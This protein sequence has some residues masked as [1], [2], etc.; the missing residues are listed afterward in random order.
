MPEA[1]SKFSASAAERWMGCPG[2]MVLEVG[3]ADST[4]EYAAE[5]TVAHD[6]AAQ[7]LRENSPVDGRRA[8]HFLG[9][10]MSADGFD[11]V[12]DE[13]MAKAVNVY[14]EEVYQRAATG[15]LLVEVQVNYADTL[16]MRKA[17]AWG[18][19]DAIIVRETEIEVI[20]LKFGRGKEVDAE[21]NKQMMLYALGALEEYDGI[22]GDFETVRMTIIQPRIKDAPSE[23]SCTVAELRAWGQTARS[24]AI[25][26]CQAEAI[27]ATIL[28]EADA[29]AWRETFLRPGEEQCRW[30]KAKATCPALRAEVASTV[31][32]HVPADPDEFAELPDKAAEHVPVADVKWL[33]A[34]LAKADMI[35]GWLKAVRG[36]VERR[37]LAGEG[38]PGYKLVQ[39]KRGNRAWSNKAD[40][41]ALLKS[42]RLKVEEMYELSLISPT[43][44]EKLAPKY[45][46]DGKPIPPKEGTPPPLIGPRQWPKLKELIVQADGKPSVAP[47]EDP[48]PALEIKPVADDFADQSADD[49]ELA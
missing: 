1:H 8:H 21:R 22:A 47:A 5:G 30:C 28:D 17:D 15:Q 14:I 49:T 44:A 16:N 12:V 9:Q 33:A 4:S 29:F 34:A 31:F 7:C 26:V 46:K 11:F 48:R 43:A 41:E 19:S 13:D 18:T 20:D 27:G 10:T 37:L 23:W 32:S 3:A 24:H 39:G 6:I 45:G 25:S 38:V 40:A 2:S 36:E 35:D 42:M